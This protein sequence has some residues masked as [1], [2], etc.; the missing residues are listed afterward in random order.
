MPDGNK[1]MA[2]LCLLEF[3]ERNGH[4]WRIRPTDEEDETV[5]LF[6]AVAAGVVSRDELQAWLDTHLA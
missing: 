1:R 4:T 5:A 3:V 2:F 6:E